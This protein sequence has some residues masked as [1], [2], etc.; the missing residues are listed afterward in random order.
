MPYRYGIEGY[1]L[2]FCAVQTEK[3]F[4]GQRD[5]TLPT[6]GPPRRQQVWEIPPLEPEITAYQYHSVCCPGCHA[7]VTAP[8]PDDVPP[9][10]AA[11]QHC[12]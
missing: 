6:V 9:G 1:F 2:A 11:P 10:A 8:R 4:S 12:R 5:N 7:W 3:L